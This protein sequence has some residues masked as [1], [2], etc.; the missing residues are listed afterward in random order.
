M[1]EYFEHLYQIKKRIPTVDFYSIQQLLNDNL[2][3]NYYHQNASN[4]KKTA[5][6]KAEEKSRF[7]PIEFIYNVPYLIIFNYEILSS[8]FLN[9]SKQGMT[10]YFFYN[11]LVFSDLQDIIRYRNSIGMYDTSITGFKLK[12]LLVGDNS[13]DD[14]DEFSKY[15]KPRDKSALEIREV[16]KPMNYNKL[17]KVDYVSYSLLLFTY[18]HDDNESKNN[19]HIID[20]INN[21]PSIIKKGG[22]FR[23]AIRD[24]TQD[25]TIYLIEHI[26][27]YFEKYK[28][29]ISENNYIYKFIYF[30][31]YKGFFEKI[32]AKFTVSLKLRNEFTEFRKKE[33]IKKKNI[34]EKTIFYYH[35][36]SKMTDSELYRYK[37][38]RLHT[39]LLKVR[40]KF[41][42]QENFIPFF[43]RNNLID[44][45]ETDSLLYRTSYN[46][47]GYYGKI[48]YFDT[49]KDN[50]ELKY[51]SE[52]KDTTLE[53]EK[54][55]YQIKKQID[56]VYS[57]QYRKIN[58][59]FKL[60]KHIKKTYANVS[61]A[62]LKAIELLH[63]TKILNRFTNVNCF[64]ACEA[65]GQFIHAFSNYCK[66]HK[67]KYNW[68]AQSLKSG[69]G[70]DYGMISKNP[71]KWDWGVDGT[72]DITNLENIKYYAKQKYHIY[73]SDCGLET[74]VFGLQEKELLWLNFAQ[75]LLG[76]LLL[77]KQGTMIV[78]IFLPCI[79]PTNLYLINILYKSFES[80]HYFKPK[81]NPSSS[82][83]Y[84][85]CEKYHPISNSQIEQLLNVYKI[86]K[87]NLDTIN[88]DVLSQHY[89]QVQ[90]LI[91]KTQQ[92]IERSIWL[93]RNSTETIKK[94][95][96]DLQRDFIQ[97]YRYNFQVYL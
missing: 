18:G 60:S 24:I 61:Q 51:E 50:V 80:I 67:I 3:Y 55:L 65:P 93:Q 72:G 30:S 9:V 48:Q 71:Q 52:I 15:I 44:T 79:K 64:H 19:D 96:S 2:L 73:T 21:L 26:S 8:S 84:L 83:F 37:K 12:Y 28:I 53:L 29:I 43:L 89:L 75:I 39:Q 35:L 56:I 63:T 6:L 16:L 36:L 40:V 1:N 58:Y 10:G 23:L 91:K 68:T 77:K 7:Q 74:K 45:E 90:N 85:V 42:K 46:D 17:D 59:Q 41:Y 87:Y 34:M 76:L 94:E 11:Q 22:C 4:Y 95:I 78:K 54:Q 20:F 66:V 92:S 33:I 27:K 32:T 5:S 82:E 97:Q 86:K 88:I 57:E 81:Q 62:F 38:E 70:D 31:K 13:V 25:R 47:V 14:K 69:F 49:I